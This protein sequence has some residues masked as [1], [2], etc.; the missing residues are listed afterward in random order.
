MRMSWR[1]SSSTS[2]SRNIPIASRCFANRW[3][4]GL[5]NRPCSRRFIFA[6]RSPL[7][8][9][10][11]CG[12]ISPVSRRSRKARACRRM[13]LTKRGKRTAP[14]DFPVSWQR[15]EVVRSVASLT[16]VGAQRE[17]RVRERRA[18][19]LLRS[20]ARKLLPGGVDAPRP[21]GIVGS[22]RTRGSTQ[23]GAR[24]GET[25]LL[26]SDRRTPQILREQ[27]VFPPRASKSAFQPILAVAD[28]LPGL[29]AFLPL[30]GH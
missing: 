18:P 5:V 1:D 21:A 10:R 30:R 14:R 3:L 26:E 12:L 4:A 7:A 25:N 2:A 15:C 11:P 8:T 28:E 22:T 29:E 9:R 20:R 6:W 27:L 13:A 17:T 16:R 23:C 19:R 24:H